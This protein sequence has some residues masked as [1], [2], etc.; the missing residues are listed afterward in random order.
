M[1]VLHYFVQTQ[2]K[3]A[4]LCTSQG[5]A[6]TEEG[7]GQA[8]ETSQQELCEVLREKAQSPFPGEEI[9]QAPMYV[10]ISTI[11]NVSLG[12]KILYS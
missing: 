7:L 8:G 1:L 6:A 2:S 9:A 5:P 11:Q 3:A 12:I 4:A 10:Q